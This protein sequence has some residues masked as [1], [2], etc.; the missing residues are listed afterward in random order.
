MGKQERTALI[1]SKLKKMHPY[2]WYDSDIVPYVEYYYDETDDSLRAGEVSV[3]FHFKEE[4]ITGEVI[5][6]ALERLEDEVIAHYKSKGI[7]L[8]E[9]AD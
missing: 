4:D 6:E 9:Y 3:P 5:L 1:N 8:F 2:L 7:T